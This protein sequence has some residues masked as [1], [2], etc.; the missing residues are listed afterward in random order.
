MAGGYDGVDLDWEALHP[1]DRNRF[2]VFVT[3][4]AN[5]LHKRRKSL[6]IAVHAKTSE[7]GDWDGPKAQDWLKLG[8]AVDEFKIMTYDYSGPWSAPG[9]IAPPAWADA[10]LNHA[11]SLVPPSKI[12]MGV[13]FY[14]YNWQSGSCTDVDWISARAL[15]KRHGAT[16]HRDPSREAVFTY[17]DDRAAS[18]TVY[19]Q[20]RAAISAKLRMLLQKH[21][22]IRG[23]AIWRMGGEAASFWDEIVLK[24]R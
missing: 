3:S 11:E 18:H 7:P 19:F 24:L 5:S 12:M 4:L 14:G 8:A 21:P 1:A 2:S 9:P 6:S 15:V 23:I 10:V 20:D 22:A 13:P 17:V 16:I